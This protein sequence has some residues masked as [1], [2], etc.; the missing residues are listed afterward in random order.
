M[1]A[2]PVPDE[3]GRTQYV[4]SL[5]LTLDATGQHVL[6]ADPPDGR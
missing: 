2:S 3:H 4:S 6:P 1:V 5:A